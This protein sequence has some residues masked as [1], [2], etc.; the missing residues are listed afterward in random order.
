MLQKFR[1]PVVFER[2][3]FIILA[4]S[5]M[6]SVQGST[7]TYSSGCVQVLRQVISI[8]YILLL[9]DLNGI[10]LS[11]LLKVGALV[12]LHFLPEDPGS[13]CPNFFGA[14]DLMLLLSWKCPRHV[15]VQPK[16]PR[17]CII[18]IFHFSAYQSQTNVG[19]PWKLD[20]MA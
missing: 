6:V 8:V 19:H 17:W 18:E 7:D 11:L 9:Q 5:E 2:P 13:G 15:Q 3:M 14:K 1:E 16:L 20:V 12:V 4:W 10:G